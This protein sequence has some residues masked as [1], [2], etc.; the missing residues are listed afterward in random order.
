MSTRDLALRA[1]IVRHIADYTASAIKARRAELS[2]EMADG[3]RIAVTATD[4]PD[5]K[6]GQVWR[7]EPKGTASVTDRPG[8]TEWMAEH[9]PD[10]VDTAL[11]VAEGR[12]EEA[13]GVLRLHAPHLLV[14]H[15]LVKRWAENEVLELTKR[16]K[17][18]CGPGGELDIPGVAY[19]PPGPGVVTVKLSDD[20]PALIEEM[21]RAGRIELDGTVKELPAG[22]EQ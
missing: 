6:L 4:A 13:V 18:A 22:T 12:W 9:Y 5:L 19:E 14:P 10:G 3:D 1:L 11:Q 17:Q 7:T 21:W 8:F 16:A 2:D 15:M 20:G